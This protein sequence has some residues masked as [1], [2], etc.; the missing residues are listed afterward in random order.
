MFWIGE[1][2]VR[3]FL[4]FAPSV[5]SVFFV[6]L[7][8]KEIYDKKTGLFSAFIFSVFWVHLFYTGRLLTNVPALPFLFLSIYFFTKSI[9]KPHYLII[10]F[11]LQG[12]S[13]LIRP[14]GILIPFCLIL[15]YLILN[16]SKIK[17]LL[18]I[19]CIIITN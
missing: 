6:Y 10:S 11:A 2:G 19:C 5:I 1:V 18:T 14:E 8:G 3:F 13:Y 15:S 9:K 7:I 17:Y 16:K 4:E 12:Y